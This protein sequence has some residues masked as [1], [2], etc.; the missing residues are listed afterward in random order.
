MT[1]P[2]PAQPRHTADMD[3]ALRRAAAYFEENHEKRL[4]Q[5]TARAAKAEAERDAARNTLAEARVAARRLSSA[6]IAVAPLLDTPYPDDPTQTPWTR[7]VAPALRNLRATLD[8]HQTQE[9]P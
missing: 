9:Q 1:Q 3:D 8:Q 2:E 4:V 7:S 6:L 5:L